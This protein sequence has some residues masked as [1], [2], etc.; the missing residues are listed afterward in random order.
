MV[1]TGV[2]GEGVDLLKILYTHVKHSVNSKRRKKERFP[3]REHI[4]KGK[5]RNAKA[6][7][8]WFYI[9]LS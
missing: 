7:F 6:L 3:F 9:G 8:I 4:R 2:R 5:E 1:G